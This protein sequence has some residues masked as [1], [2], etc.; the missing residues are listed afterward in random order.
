M[1]ET[2]HPSTEQ[3]DAGPSPEPPGVDRQNLR[4]YEQ[5]RRSVTDRRIAGVAG[6]LGR[7]L[8]IDPTVLRVLF[9]VLCFF[10]GAGFV[11]YAA[12]WLLVPEDGRDEASVRVDPGTRSTLLVVAAVITVLV[13]LGNS[14]GGFGFP[15]PLVLI[16]GAALVYVVMRDSSGRRT[17]P[18]AGSGGPYAPAPYAGYTATAPGQPGQPGQTSQTGWVG[19]PA[20]GTTTYDPQQPPP[21]WAPAAPPAYQPYQP[22]PR[23]QKHGPRLFGATLALVLVALGTLGLYDAAGGS[24]LDSAYAALA[25]AVVGLMLVVGAFLGRAGGLI[26]LGLVSIVALVATSVT[27]LGVRSGDSISTTPASSANVRDTY[28]I[29]AGRVYV[30]LSEVSDPQAL[31]GRSI[32]VGARAGEV[33]V[34]LPE[35]LRTRVRTVISGPGQAELPDRVWGGVNS[36]SRS[37]YGSGAGRLDLRVHVFAGHIDVRNP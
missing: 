20:T 5:L 11:L 10:G 30:D 4:Y 14:W 36:S 31:A 37:T 16:G 25:L 33:V 7:H 26:L 17:A 12:A 24:V 8:N 9:V 1:T 34:V 13:L 28:F 2:P 35:G 22:P 18:A 19:A 23:R 15:W 6:G 21:P 3:P 27:D 32:D 29:P